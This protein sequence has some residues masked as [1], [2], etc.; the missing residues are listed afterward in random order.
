VVAKVGSNIGGFNLPLGLLIA[1]WLPKRKKWF[2]GCIVAATTS[3]YSILS[4]NFGYVEKDVVTVKGIPEEYQELETGIKISLCESDST[5]KDYAKKNFIAGA[6]FRFIIKKV[7]NG[8]VLVNL[9]RSNV[10]VQ[11]KP[12]TALK[13]Q[14]LSFLV[15][16][17]IY[18]HVLL[19]YI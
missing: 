1:A 9:K 19:C 3:S 7:T 13:P 15:P 2:R 14:K 5:S 17:F 18:F 4:V 8:E 6:S 11:M 12:W 16:R 10:Y